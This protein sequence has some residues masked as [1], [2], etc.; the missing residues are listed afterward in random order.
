[1]KSVVSPLKS[2]IIISVYQDHSA[3]SLIL[4]SLNRQTVSDFEVIIS[5]D[6]ISKSI[7]QSIINFRSPSFELQHLVQEDCGFRKNIALNRAINAAGTDHLIF[8]DG[9]CVLHP[10][11]IAAHQSFSKLGIAC[12]GRRLELGQ[13]YSEKIRNGYIKLS[14]LTNRLYF[15]LSIFAL[16]SG[17]SKNVECG[18]Y[19][20]LLQR[21]TSDREARLLGC[22]FSCSKRDLVNIN[23]F[24]EE[25]LA[26]GIGEDSDIDWRLTQSNVTIKNVKFSAIQYHLYHPRS[27]I[28]SE[29]N[30]ELFKETKRSENYTCSHGLKHN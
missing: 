23:G 19:S 18:I 3:L 22:N 5:E 25:Y 27:Y 21:L 9:D 16:V 14:R 28:A 6:G 12:A 10:E 11:F 2:S 1:L 7:E 17:K 30:R 15:F 26:P 13:E 24:N 29:K 20:K 8:I 4:E